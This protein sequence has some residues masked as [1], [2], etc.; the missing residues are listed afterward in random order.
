M[1]RLSLALQEVIAHGVALLE[2]FSLRRAD[3]L[4]IACASE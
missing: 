2:Q 4:H 1:T 3:A